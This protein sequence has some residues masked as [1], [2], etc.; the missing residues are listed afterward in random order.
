[1]RTVTVISTQKN[2]PQTYTTPATT[3]GQLR[4]LIT[5]DFGNVSEMK[6]VVKET[7]NSLDVADALLPTGNFTVFLTQAKI[8]AGGVNLAAVIAALK[9]EFITAFEE[10]EARIDD[11]EFDVAAQNDVVGGSRISE[12]DR[13]ALQQLQQAFGLR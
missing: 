11:G 8:K 5:R 3:W 10:V 4:D 1:M 6:A 12:E 9:E 13:R 7:R 2:Q